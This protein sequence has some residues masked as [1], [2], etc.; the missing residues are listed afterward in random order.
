M[1]SLA[2]H[3]LKNAG[4][5][6]KVVGNIGKPVLDEIDFQTP[7]DYVIIELS[8]YMLQTLQKQNF[9]SI[10]GAFFPEHLDWHG[11]KDAY[12][13]AKLNILPG[14]AHTIIFKNVQPFIP[15]QFKTSAIYCGK[16]TDYDW[17]ADFFL[18][19]GQPLFSLR[20]VQLL[21]EHNLRNI[22]AIVA[23]AEQLHLDIP[24]LHQTIKQFQP[25]PHRLQCVGTFKGIDFYDDA[26]STTPESTI[27]ALEALGANVETIFLG[28]L[29]RGYDFH[30]LIE[31]IK[32]SQIKQIVFFPESGTTIAKMLKIECP[33]SGDQT[34]S[35]VVISDRWTA[36]F[37]PS[38]KEA[39]K[40][41]YQHTSTGKICLL[42]TASPSYSIRK[43]FEEK[44]EFFQKWI[45]ELA[46]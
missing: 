9:I 5:N 31:K 40:F 45:K 43:N 35:K 10:L 21:G 12:L 17:N 2:Y 34:S 18:L 1:T 36:L 38:M 20:D 42:S 44:G 23:L 7:Y 41:A 28:G 24:V 29:D 14:S 46:F 25:V 22:S 39:V 37:T 4:Y 19:R 30:T 27:A 16:G 6:V 8:S 11:G 13:Q 3:L 33:F 15:E 26:I 32:K